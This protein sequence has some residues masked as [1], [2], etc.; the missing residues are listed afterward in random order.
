MILHVHTVTFCM[1]RQKT[2][3]RNDHSMQIEKSPEL[4][5]HGTM[6]WPSAPHTSTTI[7]NDTP[8]QS[9]SSLN[10]IVHNDGMKQRDSRTSL[11]NNTGVEFHGLNDNF[12]RYSLPTDRIDRQISEL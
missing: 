4:R 11:D 5:R 6:S 10:A 3:S 2:D 1:F 12:N 7:T 9:R 8:K